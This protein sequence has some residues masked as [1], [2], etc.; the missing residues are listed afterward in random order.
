MS[1]GPEPSSGHE[2]TGPAVL[3]DAH[4][5]LYGCFDRV[6]F[7]DSALKNFRHAA[8][9]L[10]LPAHTPACLL[11]TEMSRDH[12]FES[13]ITQHELD[14][15]RWKFHPASEGRSLVATKDGRDVLTLIAGR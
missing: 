9:M 4:V 13:L 2:A 1:D 15:G 5:H 6:A 10:G 3:V 11:L 14:G 7:F 12:A 8:Q